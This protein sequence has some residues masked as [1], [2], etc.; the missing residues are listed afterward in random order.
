M[1]AFRLHPPLPNDSRRAI[2]DDTLPDV[3]HKPAGGEFSIV[4]CAMGRAEHI[5]GDDAEVFRPDR[6]LGKMEPSPF[7][8]PLFW[9]GPRACL[10]RPLALME[11]KLAMCILLTSG[12][13]FDDKLGHSGEMFWRL[14]TSM[15][16]GFQIRIAARTSNELFSS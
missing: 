16:D 2:S 9:G 1:E 6:F 11:M 10:G 3:T 7:E 12:L 15:I 14:T 5:W 4:I 13:T 8:F